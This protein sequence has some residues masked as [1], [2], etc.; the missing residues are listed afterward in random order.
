MSV[1]NSDDEYSGGMHQPV[2]LS[3]DGLPLPFPVQSDLKV[4]LDEKKAEFIKMGLQDLVADAMAKKTDDMMKGLANTFTATAVDHKNKA[5]E[6][7]IRKLV[8][9]IIRDK[10]V[11]SLE[12]KF[13]FPVD[14]VADEVLHEVYLWIIKHVEGVETEWDIYQ[15]AQKYVMYFKINKEEVEF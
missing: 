13:G 7:F 4:V 1:W 5:I 11:A 10:A 6:G 3:E 15:Q 9:H 12:Q 8:L 14:E 2:E